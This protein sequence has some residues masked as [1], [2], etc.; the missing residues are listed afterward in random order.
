MVDS[1][2]PIAHNLPLDYQLYNLVDACGPTGIYKKDLR[3]RF[4][5]L[6]ISG[7]AM[8]RHMFY[9]SVSLY[10]SYTDPYDKS[11]HPRIVTLNQA[12]K[13]QMLL[14]YSNQQPKWVLQDEHNPT[15]EASADLM[16]VQRK[17]L[18]S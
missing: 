12:Q 9:P 15:G 5:M 2:L 10:T 16:R 1:A 6:G 17:T 11:I 4:D 14:R 3:R 7:R 18:L 13:N 8:L